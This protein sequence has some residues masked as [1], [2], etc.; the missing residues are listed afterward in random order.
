MKKLKKNN[1]TTLKNIKR[2]Y[3]ELKHKDGG[4]GAKKKNKMC[5]SSP[6]ID[7][8]QRVVDQQQKSFPNGKWQYNK[9]Y[10]V[11]NNKYNYS[12]HEK[13]INEVNL[14]NKMKSGSYEDF[15]GY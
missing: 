11:V 4:G 12:P 9:Q 2:M 7:P 10:T 6:A 1:L 15:E 8:P 13:A 5:M 3:A 14:K